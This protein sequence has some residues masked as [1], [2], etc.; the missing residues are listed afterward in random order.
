MRIII[1]EAGVEYRIASDRKI[2]TPEDAAEAGK[3][4][5]QDESESFV[6]LMLD[7]RNGLKMSEVVT[8]GTLDSSLVHPREVFRPAI[9]VG[10]AA[11]VVLHNHPSGDTTPSAEDIRSTRQLVQ[12]G[13]IVGIRVLDHVIVG[14]GK[15]SDGTTGL[16]KTSLR[17]SGLVEFQ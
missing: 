15:L 16:V 11:V 7:T 13:Q 17:E 6:V 3:A 12:A 1:E 2:R 5:A 14:I 4:I 10:A 9:A 8:K